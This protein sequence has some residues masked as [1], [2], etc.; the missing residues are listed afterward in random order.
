MS[1][2]DEYRSSVGSLLDFTVLTYIAIFIV[3]IGFYLG[4]FKHNIANI[5]PV[6]LIL[7]LGVLA[8]AY[9]YQLESCADEAVKPLFRQWASLSIILI[10]A[11]FVIILGYPIS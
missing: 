8:W 2:L 7:A 6:I 11:I 9:R 5:M 1:T 10:L 4:A 3:S